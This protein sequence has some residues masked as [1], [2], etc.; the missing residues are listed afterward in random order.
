[1]NPEIMLALTSKPTQQQILQ[2]RDEEKKAKIDKL[3]KAALEHS[4]ETD[5]LC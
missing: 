4:I 3:H 1:M 2:L 5:P